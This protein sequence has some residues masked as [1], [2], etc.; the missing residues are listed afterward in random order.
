[1]WLWAGQFGG[2][3][4][5]A[6]LIPVFRDTLTWFNLVSL[7]I[8]KSENRVFGWKSIIGHVW[9]KGPESWVVESGGPFSALSLVKARGY[10]FF[11]ITATVFCEWNVG[12]WIF[13][14][15]FCFAESNPLTLAVHQ[16]ILKHHATQQG[17]QPA[18]L[19]ERLESFW[20]SQRGSVCL[21]VCGEQSREGFLVWNAGFA[22]LKYQAHHSFGVFS[23]DS[24]T[25]IPFW[26]MFH[27]VWD[28]LFLAPTADLHE[29]LTRKAQFLAGAIQSVVW[30]NNCEAGI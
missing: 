8:W 4:V 23:L 5:M 6:S 1:M 22:S 13:R 3:L 15:I 17:W 26:N 14:N 20:H 28:W 16:W 29:P 30:F 2:N 25:P 18:G 11:A 10:L 19:R 7:I 9:S 24:S 12:A 27:C 21:R